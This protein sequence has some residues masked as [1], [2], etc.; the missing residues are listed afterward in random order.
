M[1]TTNPNAHTASLIRDKGDTSMAFFGT[2]C[3]SCL[4]V[5]KEHGKTWHE[6]HVEMSNKL[7]FMFAPSIERITRW[8]RDREGEEANWYVER[9]D[10]FLNPLT[11]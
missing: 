1:F 2:P 9:H 4:L 8:K 3:W 11:A 10:A 6:S 5:T 7:S